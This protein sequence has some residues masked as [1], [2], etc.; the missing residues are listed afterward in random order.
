MKNLTEVV[1]IIDRSGS[2]GGLEKDTIG[3]FN[4][5]L[6]Q[7]KKNEGD[8][9][10]STVL[11][12]D[13][14]EVIHD[15]VSLTEIKHMT[16]EQYYVRGCTALLDAF[17]FAIDHINKVQKKM[18]ESDRPEKTMF[19]IITDGQ[20]NASRH[21]SAARIREMVTK[22]KEKK[23]WEFIF[24]GANMDAITA[25]GEIGICPE[26]AVNYCCDARGTRAGYSGMNQAITR[27]RKA[28]CQTRDEE[29]SCD[30]LA[31]WKEEIDADYNSR[32]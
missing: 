19:I 12:D 3:G 23:G 11:F 17:G 6:E 26:R 24:I 13:E 27:F 9:L 5:M 14:R 29:M 18:P 8:V 16:D 20:E 1:F 2:M 30:A 4:G 7:Q 22:K 31:G 15:R 28:K 32:E 10:V 25:A 21:Y